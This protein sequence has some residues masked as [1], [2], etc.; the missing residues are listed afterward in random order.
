MATYRQP[1]FN[2]NCNI[3]RIANWAGTIPP[4]GLP[5][6]ASTCQLRM[7][8]NILPLAPAPADSS[9]GM[10]L[11]LPMG[12][13]IRGRRGWFGLSVER[14]LVEVPQGSGRYYE[15]EAVD[16][17]AKGFANEHRCCLISQRQAPAPVP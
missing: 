14:D 9:V 15:V 2:L 13:D 17:M 12:T 5:D 10:L 6:N 7:E 11:L 16:D 1:T 4:A 3:W 8:V